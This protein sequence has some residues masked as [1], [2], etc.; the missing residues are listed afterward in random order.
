MVPGEEAGV[1]AA[2]GVLADCVTEARY[3]WSGATQAVL[4]ATCQ[5]RGTLNTHAI[6]RTIGKNTENTAG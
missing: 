1:G 6:G 4:D 5:T 3:L 2:G